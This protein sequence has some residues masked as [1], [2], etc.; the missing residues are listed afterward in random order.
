MFFEF[1]TL[2]VR[3]ENIIGLPRLIYFDKAETGILSIVF[4]INFI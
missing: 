2:W 3:H 1:P 4:N